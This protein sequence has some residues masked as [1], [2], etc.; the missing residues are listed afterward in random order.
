MTDQNE[1]D[2]GMEQQP[3]LEQENAAAEQAAAE[4]TA[5]LADGEVPAAPTAEQKVPPIGALPEEPQVNMNVNMDRSCRSPKQAKSDG[6][7]P[8][9]ITGKTEPQYR[10]QWEAIRKHAGARDER[11]QNWF[12][13]VQ[14]SGHFTV[15]GGSFLPSLLRPNSDWGQGI[16]HESTRLCPGSP[17]I[18]AKPGEK[19]TGERAIMR[20]QTAMGLGATVNVP[21]VHSGIWVT[22]KAP[23]DSELLTLERTITEEKIKLGRESNG[24]VYSNS[25]SYIVGHLMRFIFDHIYDSSIKELENI[26]QFM[27]VVRATDINTLI[28]AMACTVY[29]NGYPFR[30]PCISHPDN[31]N[32]ILEEHL[33]LSKLWW[34]DR[35]SLSQAQKRH[36]ADRRGKFTMEQI[37]AY[38]TDGRIGNG[39]TVELS[40]KLKMVLKVPTV[41]QYILAGFGWVEG[42]VDMVE[43]ALGTKVMGK[44]K[45]DLIIQH[46]VASTFRQYSHWVA[47]IVFQEEDE[48]DD[49]ATIEDILEMLSTDRDLYTKFFDE[50]KTY[51]DE[52]TISMIAYPS[53]SCPQCEKPQGPEESKHPNLIPIEVSN[54]FFTLLG[55]RILRVKML[56]TN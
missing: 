33:N 19:L 28:W 48:I 35:S 25:T 40:S 1:N 6:L 11:G 4:Q 45:Q 7:F 5:L 46:S 15:P 43:K 44:D 56:A 26:D 12:Q 22:L 32:Y 52:C 34:V 3:S 31:C 10:R 53:W 51:I 27:Q 8:I 30:Q 55:L 50:I 17:Q 47:K 2:T 39:K 42:I 14:L 36:L 23:T 38:Q 21:L 49:K 9:I 18:N 20:V 24:L 41:E 16:D 29:P 13:S 54:L 37:Q